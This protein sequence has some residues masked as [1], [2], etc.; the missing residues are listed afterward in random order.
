VDNTKLNKILDTVIDSTEDSTTNLAGK[1][2]G[3]MLSRKSPV[4]SFLMRLPPHYIYSAKLLNQLLLLSGLYAKN[5]YTFGGD[6]NLNYLLPKNVCFDLFNQKTCDLKLKKLINMKSY[7]NVYNDIPTELQINPIMRGGGGGDCLP[8]DPSKPVLCDTPSGRNPETFMDDP[9]PEI[10]ALDDALQHYVYDTNAF[11]DITS[12]HKDVTIKLGDFDIYKLHKMLQILKILYF[13]TPANYVEPPEPIDTTKINIREDD[14]IHLEHPFR[15]IASPDG[16]D[17]NHMT[18]KCNELLLGQ[19]KPAVL[20]IEGNRDVA[21]D[22]LVGECLLQCSD[23]TP[24][25]Q[26]R[27]YK[28]GNAVNYNPSVENSFDVLIAIF[29]PY[30]KHTKSNKYNHNNIYIILN[31]D[32]NRIKLM[33]NINEDELFKLFNIG[34][35]DQLKPIDANM[36]KRLHL[37]SHKYKTIM[38]HTHLAKILLYKLFVEIIDKDTKDTFNTNVLNRG[39]GLSI[40]SLIR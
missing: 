6:T 25:A 12:M 5:L 34:E 8:N 40:E 4:Q 38:F 20:D 1:I 23:C 27:M 37:I 11:D 21:E 30:F 13:I 9:S 17:F 19:N 26:N 33:K 24:E 28:I 15:F 14:I 3:E 29:L 31:N 18:T 35:P 16:E 2:F 7:T 22:P 36:L 39:K 10:V 32:T